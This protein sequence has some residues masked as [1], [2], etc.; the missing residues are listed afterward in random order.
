M[1]LQWLWMF[2]ATLLTCY[3]FVSK[4]MRN[5]N[6]WY[7]DLKFKNKQYPLPPGDM[8]WPFIG[9]L[10]TFFKYF[11]SGRGETF[12]NNIVHKFGRIGI[13]KTHLYGSPS[14]IVIAPAICKKVLIDEVTFKIGYPKAATELAKSKLLN[15]EN[16]RFKRLVA[17]PIIGRNV[18]EMYL[19]RIEDIVINKLEELSSMKHPVEFLMEMRKASFEFVIHI[20]LGS[21]DQSNVKKFGD[22]FNV[23]CIALFSLVPI[24]VPGFA[25]NKALKVR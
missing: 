13:Y 11:S 24:N 2:A 17:A 7:Y 21:C 12:I 14:I 3:I 9:N 16:G 4:V 5:L 25:Y 23:M 1:E 19:E 20:F 6:G 18:L 22:L 8:G 10:W 15:S